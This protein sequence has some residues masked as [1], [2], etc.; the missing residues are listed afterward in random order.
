MRLLA[1]LS[2]ALRLRLRASRLRPRA[3]TLIPAPTQGLASNLKRARSRFARRRAQVNDR[4]GMLRPFDELRP[5]A[6]QLS[7]ALVAARED[8]VAVAKP[9]IA[10]R[11]APEP[12]APRGCQSVATA[13]VK[14]MEFRA[15]TRD[16]E[17]MS[18]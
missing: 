10:F 17:A 14:Q 18:P 1:A 5:P 11:P 3:S 2:R 16:H 15:V 13:R 8:V 6:G 7:R 9:H 12:T 4:K